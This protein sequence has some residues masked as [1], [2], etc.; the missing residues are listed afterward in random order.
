[1][2]EILAPVVPA[3]G[4]VALQVRP[5]RRGGTAPCEFNWQERTLSLN[6]NDCTLQFHEAGGLARWHDRMRSC[7]WCSAEVEFPLGSV[8]CD[9]GCGPEMLGSSGVACPSPRTR[10]HR[11][12]RTR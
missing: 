5:V 8:L 12:V 7:Q 2:L 6:R 10:G 4:Y 9:V 11:A 3:F 1:M